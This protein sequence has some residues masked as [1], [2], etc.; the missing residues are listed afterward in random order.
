MSA[1]P[2]DAV[3]EHFLGWQCRIR[4]IAM[5]QDGGRPSP[6]MRPRVLTITGRELS[7][8]LTV[9]IVPKDPSESTAFF[10][11]QVQ[12]T[13]DSRD[14]YE[15]GL[16]YLKADYFQQPKTFSDQLTA[17]LAKGSTLLSAMVKAG[18]SVLQFGQF[19]QRYRFPSAVS[20][21]APGDPAYEASIWHNRIFNPAMA[22]TA[23]V[24]AIKPN[25][26]AGEAEPPVTFSAAP[27]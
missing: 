22:E 9:L 20:V 11:F 12:K 10:R 24:I 14:V 13:R 17:V 3:R 19:Q 15:R 26:E 16:A 4:Q 1:N 2:A 23:Q 7:P 6:G 21:L 5:R 25:W 27:R 8:A 18:S